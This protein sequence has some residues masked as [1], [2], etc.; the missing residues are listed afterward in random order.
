M[1]LKAF[2]R[3]YFT[4][5][6]VITYSGNEAAVTLQSRA[7]SLSCDLRYRPEMHRNPNFDMHCWPPE[8]HTPDYRGGGGLSS[9][10]WRK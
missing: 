6:F 4:M 5:F 10:Y 3:R 1:A 8:T 2:D 7:L 9:G